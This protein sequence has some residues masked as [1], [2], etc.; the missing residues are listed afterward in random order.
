M[1]QGSRINFNK[2]IRSSVA[3]RDG[4]GGCGPSWVTPSQGVTPR[5]KIINLVVKMLKNILGV[6]W[7]QKVSGKFRVINYMFLCKRIKKSSKMF[8]MNSIFEC[9]RLKIFHFDKVKICG[10]RRL[11]PRVTTS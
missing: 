11:P 3:S 1:G 9:K 4:G 10:G 6:K 8:G 7:F 2:L 5:E